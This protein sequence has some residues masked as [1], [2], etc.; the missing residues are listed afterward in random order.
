MVVS[1]FSRTKSIHKK[2][3]K[4]KGHAKHSP[5]LH[6]TLRRTNRPQ[7]K[8]KFCLN[9]WFIYR[10][11]FHGLFG[12]IELVLVCSRTNHDKS[13]KTLQNNSNANS[14]TSLHLSFTCSR[15]WNFS[16]CECDIVW[17]ILQHYDL[18]TCNSSIHL[19]TLTAHLS[20]LKKWAWYFNPV[21][22]QYVKTP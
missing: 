17:Q 14:H 19:A 6:H 7:K 16:R 18:L 10:I 5:M 21:I 4:S 15:D 3:Q 1:F 13:D 11:I 8:Y 2:S 22:K 20:S 9:T 12:R